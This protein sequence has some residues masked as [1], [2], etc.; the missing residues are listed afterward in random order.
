MHR[1]RQ[2]LCRGLPV[3]HLSIVFPDVL[4]NTYQLSLGVTRS[5]PKNLFSHALILDLPRLPVLE[6]RPEFYN[7]LLKL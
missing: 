4:Q 7:T 3:S 5:E 2:H 6:G 1:I